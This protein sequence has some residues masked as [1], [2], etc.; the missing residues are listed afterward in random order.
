MRSTQ[1]KTAVKAAVVAACLATTAPLMLACSTDDTPQLDV[2]G[3]PEPE[4]ISVEEWLARYCAPFIALTDAFQYYDVVVADPPPDAEEARQVYLDLYSHMHT[5]LIDSSHSFVELG[6][7]PVTDIRPGLSEHLGDATRRAAEG[8]D[9]M[10]IDLEEMEPDDPVA[11]AEFNDRVEETPNPI[12]VAFE[13]L[14][15][16][17]SAEL[18]GAIGGVPECSVL[19]QEPEPE[20]DEAPDAESEREDDEGE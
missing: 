6:D 9:E 14:A 12:A 3:T 10:R 1:R 13:D 4:P 2:D 15:E 18:D 5:V 11:V 19:V 7:P 8:V 20:P 16:F 17:E